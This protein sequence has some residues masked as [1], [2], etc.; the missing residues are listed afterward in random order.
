M[1]FVPPPRY[2]CKIHVKGQSAAEQE[3][4]REIIQGDSQLY[5]ATFFSSVSYVST[6]PLACLFVVYLSFFIYSF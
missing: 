4:I 6:L 1:R 2:S 3:R 5:F